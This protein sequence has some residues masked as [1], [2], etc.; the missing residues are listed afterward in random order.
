MQCV[1]CDRRVL[2][3]HHFPV[4]V[5]LGGGDAELLAAVDQ[6]LSRYLN[7]PY[8][9]ICTCVCMYVNIANFAYMYQFLSRYLNRSA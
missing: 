1:H 4:Q 9:C 6:F 8:I 7:R 3:L 5:V 2:S